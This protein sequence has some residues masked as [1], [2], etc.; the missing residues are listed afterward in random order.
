MN[1]TL[2]KGLTDSELY[3]VMLDAI[4]RSIR[5]RDGRDQLVVCPSTGQVRILPTVDSVLSLPFLEDFFIYVSF[6]MPLSYKN[7]SRVNI[8]STDIY[9]DIKRYLDQ[10]GGIAKARANLL[11]EATPSTVIYQRV[12]DLQVAISELQ[13]ELEACYA[14]LIA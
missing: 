14:E 5:R 2:E 13:N 4:K 3:Q 9:N 10:R 11:L 1:V 6:D 8:S 7:D 12:T